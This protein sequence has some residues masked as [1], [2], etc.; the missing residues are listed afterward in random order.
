M[1]RFLLVSILFLS[2]VFLNANELTTAQKIKYQISY[3]TRD[4]ANNINAFSDIIPPKE[5]SKYETIKY[6]GI[7]IENRDLLYDNIYEYLV[8]FINKIVVFIGVLLPIFLIIYLLPMFLFFIKNR[9]KKI[10]AFD[11]I[12]NFGILTTLSAA[13]VFLLYILYFYSSVLLVNFST[14]LANIFEIFGVLLVLII[15][16]PL[17]LLALVFE[18]SNSK[19]Q[20]YPEGTIKDVIVELV[21]YHASSIG[22]SVQFDTALLF[23]IFK[24]VLFFIVLNNINLVVNYLFLKYSQTFRVLIKF[25]FI[26]GFIFSI[27]YFNYELIQK[28]GVIL[29]ELGSFVLKA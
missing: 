29:Y 11:R 18:V 22:I 23:M 5:L 10:N 19:M 2:S 12:V 20:F 13:V 14:I 24:L 27:F 1:L 28:L 16:T 7:Q 6:L 21:N 3:D 26:F 25:V 9:D 8:R 17:L 15:L 4:S